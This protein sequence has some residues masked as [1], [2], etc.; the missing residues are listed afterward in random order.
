MVSFFASP[1]LVCR[2]RRLEDTLRTHYKV[3][4]LSNNITKNYRNQTFVLPDPRTLADRKE[5]FTV[6]C[7]TCTVYSLSVQT[8]YSLSVQTLHNYNVKW[9]FFSSPLAKKFL[10]LSNLRPTR[11]VIAHFTY[12][13]YRNKFPPGEGRIRRSFIFV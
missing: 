1:L 9:I 5:T 3:E 13:K 4:Y 12:S 10:V 11:Q 6:M 7:N 8:V 2:R